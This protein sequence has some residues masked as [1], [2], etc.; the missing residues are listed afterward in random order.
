MDLDSA[1]AALTEECERGAEIVVVSTK[2]IAIVV[3]DD[4]EGFI[5]IWKCLGAIGY[6]VRI[7]PAA[8][9]LI[10]NSRSSP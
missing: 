3:P 9:L 4:V 2:A 1:A 7:E 10:Y 6:F 5:W 8:N